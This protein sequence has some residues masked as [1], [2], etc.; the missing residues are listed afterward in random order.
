MLENYKLNRS[1]LQLD[2]KLGIARTM[3]A[4]LSIKANT[5]LSEVEMQNLV[6]Q[7]FGCSV[8]E[9]APDGKKIYVLLTLDELNGKLKT[10]NGKL[11]TPNS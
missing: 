10:E 9:V 4:Q 5:T 6:D 7:L 1:N 8:A 11:L 2:R 3:A